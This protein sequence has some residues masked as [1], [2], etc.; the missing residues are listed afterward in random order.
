MDFNK[1]T[2]KT[3]ASA[4]KSTASVLITQPETVNG[5][6]TESLRRAHIDLFI[7]GVLE[8]MGLAVVDGALCAILEN[9]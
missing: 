5:V 4:V 1:I 2:E 6:S 3:Q 8:M 7:D 9:D